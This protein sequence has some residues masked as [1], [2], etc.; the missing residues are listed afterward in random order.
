ML[1][2]TSVRLPEVTIAR[3][4]QL[5]D[6]YGTSTSMILSMAIDRMWLAELH[7]QPEGAATPRHETP[8]PTS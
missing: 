5:K 1:Q 3:I 7:Y 4:A 6:L 2:H 8:R